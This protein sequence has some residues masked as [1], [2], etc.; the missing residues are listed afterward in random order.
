M[1]ALKKRNIVVLLVIVLS[2]VL[3]H[4]VQA[5]TGEPGSE[6]NPL[7]TQDYVDAKFEELSEK[8]SE[9]STQYTE[10]KIAYDTLSQ[11]AGIGQGSSS[12]KFQVIELEA[13]K[14]MLLG[15]SA[16]VVLRGGKA[17]AI[18]GELGGLADLSSGTGAEYGKGQ[19]IP[20]NHLLLSSRNDGRGLK[21]TIK[22]WI[23]VKGD[24]TLQ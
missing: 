14:V 23:L 2:F 11:Q 22:A 3:V 8:F 20:L 17:T 13:G 21:A 24:Y 15:E 9:L 12:L 10:L 5:G 7:V 6:A 19:D 16:E 4:I 1:K 18:S